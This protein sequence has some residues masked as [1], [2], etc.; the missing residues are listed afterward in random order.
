MSGFEI[1]V[2]NRN[3]FH[4][5]A[6]ALAPWSGL[7]HPVYPALCLAGFLAYQIKQDSDLAKSHAKNPDSH[8]DIYEFV[9]PFIVS[10]IA[11]GFIKLGGLIWLLA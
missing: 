4:W 3:I 7:F 9:V 8:K 5:I 10:C 6:G 2:S 11:M 1:K